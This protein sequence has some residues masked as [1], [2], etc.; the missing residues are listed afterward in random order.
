MSSEATCFGGGLSGICLP[1]I[2]FIFKFLTTPKSTVFR[3]FKQIPQDV[4]TL[5]ALEKSSRHSE[6]V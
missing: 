1:I 6:Q 5:K 4:Y 3:N 2:H